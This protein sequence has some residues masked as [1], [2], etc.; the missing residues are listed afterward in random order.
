MTTT[1]H[2]KP[3]KAEK[4][5]KLTLTPAV[6]AARGFEV[7]TATGKVIEVSLADHAA[8]V[9]GKGGEVIVSIPVNKPVQVGDEITYTFQKSEDGKIIQNA[10]LAKPPKKP[11]KD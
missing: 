5:V 1:F 10:Q 3:V 2:E 6:P 9:D 7:E 11:V 4:P 8:I